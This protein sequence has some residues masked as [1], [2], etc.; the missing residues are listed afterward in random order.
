MGT[1]IEGQKTQTG[2]TCNGPIGFLFSIKYKKTVPLYEYLTPEG[3]NYYTTHKKLY[4]LGKKVGDKVKG[5]ATYLGIVGYIYPL[6]SKFI[7]R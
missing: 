2:Y 5:G 3:F 4:G 7:A 6:K 1:K